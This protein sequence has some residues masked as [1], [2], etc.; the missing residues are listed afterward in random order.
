MEERGVEQKPSWLL[1][2]VVMLAVLLKTSQGVSR[3]TDASTNP[4]LRLTLISRDQLFE[5][6][7]ASFEYQLQMRIYLVLLRFRQMC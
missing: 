3:A 4:T 2:L 5:L 1:G 7:D 6:R